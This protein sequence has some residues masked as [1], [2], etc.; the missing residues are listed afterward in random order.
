[1]DLVLALDSKSVVHMSFLVV[2]M[3]FYYLFKTVEGILER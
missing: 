2:H 1:M 3:S